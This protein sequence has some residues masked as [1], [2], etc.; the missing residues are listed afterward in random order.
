MLRYVGGKYKLAKPLVNVIKSF[1]IGKSIYIE[2]FCGGLGT[3]VETK[4]L[5]IQRYYSDLNQDLVDLFIS[6][7]G[8]FVPPETVSEEQYY[9][10]KSSDR[11]PLRTYVGYSCSF[12]GKFFGGY[13][14]DKTGKRDL[15]L[16]SY[17]R[18][19]KFRPYVDSIFFACHNFDCSPVT[20][21]ALVYCDPPYKLTLGYGNSF[22]TD[23]F[24][25]VIRE[26]SK[27]TIVLISEFEAPDDFVS[28]WSK[29]RNICLHH[30]QTNNKKEEKLF[31]HRTLINK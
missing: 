28:I 12:G 6:I 31:M 14:R 3:A 22:N 25:S 17:R 11:S 9:A 18:F 21:E 15:T 27:K 24:W 8:G 13:A 29:D 2:P 5:G 19:E 23:Y 1:V 7:Q 4:Q 26:W 10:L 16:E 30:E 20:A